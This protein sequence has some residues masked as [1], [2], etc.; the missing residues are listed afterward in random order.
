MAVSAG[1]DGQLIDVEIEVEGTICGTVYREARPERLG[2]FTDALGDGSPRTGPALVLPMLASPESA[3]GILV[4]LR[5]ASASHFDAAQ[6]EL[7]SA[8][9]EQTAL[10]VRLAEDRRAERARGALRP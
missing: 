1:D 3:L 2:K 4:I 5:G 8:F 10:A 6:L 9:A 7:A